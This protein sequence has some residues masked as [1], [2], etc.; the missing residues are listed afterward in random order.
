MEN[1]PMKVS[2]I[3]ELYQKAQSEKRVPVKPR[4]PRDPDEFKMIFEKECEALKDGR[5]EKI[6]I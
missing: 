1:V 5:K 3:L 2:E 6:S 4:K